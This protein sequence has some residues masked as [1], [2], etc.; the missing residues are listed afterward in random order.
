MMQAI[1]ELMLEVDGNGDGFIDFK[2]PLHH[3]YSPP[4]ETPSSAAMKT[5]TTVGH[6]C[7]ECPS[8]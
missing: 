8:A 1:A 3:S 7:P 4:T 5:D 6:A 2:D